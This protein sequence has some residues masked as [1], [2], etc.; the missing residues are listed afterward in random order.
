MKSVFS[1][2]VALTLVVVG[3]GIMGASSVLVPALLIDVWDVALIGLAVGTVYFTF[4]GLCF[5]FLDGDWSVSNELITMSPSLLTAAFLGAVGASGVTM[6]IAATIARYELGAICVVTLIA[7]LPIGLVREAFRKMS[8]EKPSRRWA[9]AAWLAPC[10][11][12]DT[13]TWFRPD[14]L[15][16]PLT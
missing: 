7:M 1:E 13:L 4:L 6:I 2:D 10:I 12:L 15:R 8:D 16:L 5:W 14:L 9:I 3:A 11:V